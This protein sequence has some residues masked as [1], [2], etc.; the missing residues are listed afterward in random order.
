MII[1]IKIF[2]EKSTADIREYDT[3]WE[4]NRDRFIFLQTNIVVK[5]QRGFIK[6]DIEENTN[7]DILA[8]R[9]PTNLFMK[10]NK[11]TND[12][13]R[14]NKIMIISSKKN[15]LSGNATHY[16]NVNEACGGVNTRK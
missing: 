1:T 15:D 16:K 4:E 14:N 8:V 9:F 13:T 11:I 2:H 7:K 5:H 3:L 10:K 6:D 12:I